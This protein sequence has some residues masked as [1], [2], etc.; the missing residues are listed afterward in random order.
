MF[1]DESTGVVLVDLRNNLL[2]DHPDILMFNFG[3][4]VYFEM[5]I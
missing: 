1:N 5:I 2:K 3:E 4:R